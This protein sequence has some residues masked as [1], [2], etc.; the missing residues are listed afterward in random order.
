LT[1]GTTTGG[2]TTG[3]VTGGGTTTT[4]GGGGTTGGKKALT[5]GVNTV[6]GIAVSVIVGRT[7]FQRFLRRVAMTTL[8]LDPVLLFPVAPAKS[9]FSLSARKTV[10]LQHFTLMK[11]DVPE[12]AIWSVW[13]VVVVWIN[14]SSA[15]I[16]WAD[17]SP[18]RRLQ[19]CGVLRILGQ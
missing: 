9:P 2:T 5:V 4:T 15:T 8:L 10:W 16:R 6:K 17:L 13:W 7:V 1:G 3:G 19:R 14:E 11:R 12:R 18:N